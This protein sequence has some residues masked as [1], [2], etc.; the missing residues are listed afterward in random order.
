MNIITKGK[1][2]IKKTY[3]GSCTVCGSIVQFETGEVIKN[4]DSFYFSKEN[5]PVCHEER[6][7]VSK[8]EEED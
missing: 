6:I 7:I 2:P 5:C 4:G 1:P 3:T 8:D